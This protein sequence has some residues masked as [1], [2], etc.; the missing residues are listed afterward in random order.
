MEALLII[1]IILV[2]NFYKWGN[3]ERLDEQIRKEEDERL[4]Q[5]RVID[6]KEMMLDKAWDI[7]TMAEKV[8]TY[9]AYMRLQENER[10][11]EKT[12]EDEPDYLEVMEMIQAAMIEA[13]ARYRAKEVVAPFDYKYSE[14]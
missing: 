4:A 1:A 9:A 7:L 5:R 8:K 13:K 14:E 2:G 11:F 12:Y 3:T 6:R 10:L